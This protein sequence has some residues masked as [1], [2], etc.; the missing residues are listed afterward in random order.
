M[1]WWP[2]LS[3]GAMPIYLRWSLLCWIFQLKSSPL[4]PGIFLFP[5]HLGLFSGYPEFP[6]PHCY[7]FLFNFPTLYTSLL[8]LPILDL[9]L[10]SL[11]LPLLSHSQLQHITRTH[12]PLYL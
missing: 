6:I 1:G 4:G 5:W 10:L 8:S 12:V 2:H 11:S 3:T 9:A 7:I